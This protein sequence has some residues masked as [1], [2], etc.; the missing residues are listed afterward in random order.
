MTSPVDP[1]VLRRKIAAGKR[2]PDAG[3]DPAPLATRGLARALR[4]AAVPFEGLG[5]LPDAPA[6]SAALD[7]DM[8]MAS[9]P[10]RGLLAVIEDAA[11]LRGLIALGHGLVDALVEVQT[12]GRIEPVEMPPRPVTRIDEAL[13]RDF[14][15]LVLAALGRELAGIPGRDWPARLSYASR[16]RDRG[17]VALMLSE[18][19]YR[20]LTATIGFDGVARRAPIA[21]VLPLEVQMPG[22]AGTD[23]L[24][25]APDPAWIAARTRMVEG[26]DLPLEAILLRRRRPLAEVQGLSVGDLLR[27]DPSDLLSV[28]LE[29]PGGR[30]LATGRLG[31]KGGR[32][33]LCLTARSPAVVPAAPQPP[34]E[35]AQPPTLHP[36]PTPPQMLPDL[37]PDRAAP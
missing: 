6:L 34:V 29:A 5:L 9:V 8:A 24:R 10:E 16:I 1:T 19:A 30:A 31:Q 26:L 3:P 11:G 12:T 4:H 33:A 25:M 17:Q 7:L 28:T 36:S 37:P 22:V 18:G 15:D 32:R 35:Q 13:A 20:L 21:L 27:F 2:P 14:V 23:P